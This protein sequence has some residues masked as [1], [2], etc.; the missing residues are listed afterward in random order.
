MTTDTWRL[1]FFLFC[2][3]NG[4]YLNKNIYL[5]WNSN[6]ETIHIALGTKGLKEG[7]HLLIISHNSTFIGLYSTVDNFKLVSI[8]FNPQNTTKPSSQININEDKLLVAVEDSNYH[9][10]PRIPDYLQSDFYLNTSILKKTLN[11]INETVNV[12]V[13]FHYRERSLNST[14]FDQRI[15]E[16]FDLFT[17]NPFLEFEASYRLEY[18]HESTVALTLF[19][20]LSLSLICLFLSLKQPLKARGATSFMHQII[21]F[22]YFGSNCLV[23][24]D[25]ETQYN[26]C[27]IFVI[28]TFS[29][30]GMIGFIFGL[31]LT[32]IMV[33]QYINKR[34]IWFIES[35]KDNS[36]RIAQ[37][38]KLFTFIV[39]PITSAIIILLWYLFFVGVMMIPIATN[40]FRCNDQL[41]TISFNISNFFSGFSFL[42][43]IICFLVDIML[44]INLII[45]CNL[46]ELFKQDAYSLKLEFYICSAV[47]LFWFFVSLFVAN[48]IEEYYLQASSVSIA[49]V[50]ITILFAVLP[51]IRTIYFMIYSCILKRNASD[52][53]IDQLFEDPIL[54]YEFSEFAKGEWSTENL[55]CYMKIKQY[56]NEKKNSK[57]KELLEEIIENHLLDTSPLEVNFSSPAKVNFRK[58]YAIQSEKDEFLDDLLDEM[59]KEVY[60]N[61]SDTF[62]RFRV[63]RTF[64]NIMKTK[65]LILNE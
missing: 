48:A 11:I 2:I 55:E 23:Y 8:R 52:S 33:F 56:K 32:R 51:I 26:A 40:G 64:E 6:S 38:I 43:F 65:K 58:C 31:Y 4:Y 46:R 7:S 16:N 3:S 63:S 13:G 35:K 60:S 50:L 22:L 24:L 41:L 25:L 57:R 29:T 61:V 10:L 20:H 28:F 1:L 34:K 59:K 14:N 53:K 18:F 62:S 19:I 17:L 42:T 27:Y 36:K 49:Y 44:N 30:N 47:I 37:L 21:L 39:H 45:K 54:K 12:F 15:F 5:G 9:F